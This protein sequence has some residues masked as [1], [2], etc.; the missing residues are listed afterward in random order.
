MLRRG[1]LWLLDVVI[2]GASAATAFVLRENFDLRGDHIAAFAPY[3]VCSLLSAAVVLPM[4]GTQRII[5]RF[6]SFTD[7]LR[8]LSAAAGAVSLTVGLIFVFNRLD[9]VARSLPLL[10]VFILVALLITPRAFYRLYSMRRLARRAKLKPLQLA[11]HSGNAEHALVLGL[12]SLT[13][14][15]LRAVHEFAP[16]KVRIAGLIGRHAGHSGRLAASYPVL[17]VPEDIEGIVERLRVHGVNVQRVVVTVPWDALS[18]AARD[19]LERCRRAWGI[20]LQLIAVDLG[21]IE[22][23]GADLTPEP[24]GMRAP[25][26]LIFTISQTEIERLARNSY[27]R[28]KRLCDVALA[29]SLIVLLGPLFVLVTGV[30]ALLIGLP[31]TFWQERPGLGG[32]HFRLHK[33]R[34]MRPATVGRQSDDARTSV[35][36]SLLRRSRLDELPQLWDILRGE[37][38][39]V[40]PRPLL[41]RDQAPEFRAR[42]LVRPGLT[43]WAQVIGGRAISARDKAALDVWYVRNASLWLDLKVIGLT[44]PVILRG[45]RTHSDVISSVWDDL[46]RTGIVVGDAGHGASP[47]TRDRVAA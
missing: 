17:G 11:E 28:L 25:D 9:G 44:V 8:L 20:H 13:E 22:W 41:P 42:L 14:A 38:S 31:V 29:A 21:L 24:G 39:F 34:T 43:G 4:L 36:G 23:Q 6:T 35:A 26:G 3:F 33:F 30:V 32:R 18:Q 7:Y 40:G 27:W 47:A 16:H 5:W 45:E 15:Y 12:S 46:K 37:M 19:G 10:H 1:G 2:A